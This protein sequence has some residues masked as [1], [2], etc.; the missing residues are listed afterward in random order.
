VP[1]WPSDVRRLSGLPL[2]ALFS[3]ERP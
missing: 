1:H 2:C 3:E